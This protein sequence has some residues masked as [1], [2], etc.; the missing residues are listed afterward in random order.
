MLVLRRKKGE[1]VV[2]GG[3]ILVRVLE[4]E[5]DRVKLGFV[6]PPEVVIVREELPRSLPSVQPEA[7]QPP[8]EHLSPSPEDLSD[9]HQP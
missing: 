4:V 3:S 7:T 6:A 8:T 1:T 9:T 2:I 5:G